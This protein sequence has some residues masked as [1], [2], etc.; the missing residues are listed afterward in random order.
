M[1]NEY[2]LKSSINNQNNEIYGYKC[3]NR[4]LINRYGKQF[5]VGRTYHMD[6]EIKF[7]NDGNGFHMCMNLEDTLRY[8]DAMNN[9]VDICRV[10]GS[11]K[12]CK[13]I[14]EYNGYYYMYAFENMYI[15]KQL[16][17]EEI[18]AYGLNLHEMR[19]KRFVSQFK[20][21]QDEIAIFKEK[22]KKSYIVLDTIAY[23]QETI[24]KYIQKN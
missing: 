7:G 1:P 4:G 9:D 13:G 17:R 11:G 23:Y 19:A 15:E 2:Y 14:D 6:G 24:A 21:T 16:I 10:K 12:F 3:F 18:I 22:F 8:F 5:E 20:L